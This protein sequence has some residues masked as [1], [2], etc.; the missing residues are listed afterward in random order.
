MGK[1]AFVVLTVALSAAACQGMDRLEPDRVAA[2]ADPGE[3]GTILDSTASPDFGSG[4]R[5]TEEIARRRFR[6]ISGARGEERL[7]LASTFF[8]EYPVAAGIWEVHELVGDAYSELGRPAEA[9]A[10]WQKALE[11]SWPPIDILRL[12]QSNIE[13][14]YEIGW[15]QF[16]AGNPAAGA[17]W[18][19]RATFVSDRPQLEQ[20][21]RFVY[22]ELGSPGGDFDGWFSD[23][24]AAIAVQ[25]PDFELPGYGIESLR[26]SEI[27]ARLTL[28]NFWSPT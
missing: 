19:V 4:G 6:A 13:L 5:L 15:A 1:R 10:A 26:L 16:E 25:A 12:P 8:R 11:R 3:R 18:L 24:R 22:A 7:E 21:L 2:T 14:P 9:A 27:D 23:Q 20:G 17:D 28:I